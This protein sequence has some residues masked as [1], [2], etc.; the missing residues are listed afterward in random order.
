M[1]VK[2]RVALFAELEVW[3][4]QGEGAQDTMEA[5]CEKQIGWTVG[6]RWEEKRSESKTVSSLKQSRKGPKL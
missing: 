2:V 4:L 1:G 6:P 5:E 3:G